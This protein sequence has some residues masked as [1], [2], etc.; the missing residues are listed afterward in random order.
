MSYSQNGKKIRFA[1]PIASYTS[2]FANPR[3]G[4]TPSDFA[5]KITFPLRFAGST[6]KV[7][8]T[9]VGAPFFFVAN[10]F[11][12]FAQ[13]VMMTETY[14]GELYSATIFTKFLTASGD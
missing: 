4:M 1:M 7:F 14:N 5:N 3:D 12:D 13:Q 2:L 11:Y 9:G 6:L 8:A 10:V